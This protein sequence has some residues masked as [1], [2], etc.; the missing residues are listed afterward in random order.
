MSYEQLRR[1]GFQDVERLGKGLATEDAGVVLIAGQWPPS[2]LGPW[3]N[4]MFWRS[5][6]VLIIANLILSGSAAQQTFQQLEGVSEFERAL[7]AVDAIKQRKKLQCVMAIANGRLCGCLSRM[8]PV[9]TFIRSYGSLATPGGSPEFEQL[10][11]VDQKI[12]AQCL[13][14]SR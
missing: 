13:Y 4:K 10:S 8:L 9:D 5:F 6:G 7:A 3:R 2:L 11:A 1:D 12:V 14:E